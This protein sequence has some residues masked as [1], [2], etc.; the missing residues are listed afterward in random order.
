MIRGA[1][2]SLSRTGLLRVCLLGLA[3]L[4]VAPAASAQES[5]AAAGPVAESLLPTTEHWIGDLDG[6]RKR[7]TIRLLVPYSKTFYFVDKGGKQFGI[8]YDVGHAFEEWLNKREKTKTLKI[9]VVFIPVARDRLLSGLAD[10]LGDIAAGNI[11]I[12]EERAK[13]VQFGDPFAKDIKEVLVTGPTAAPIATL[14]D[15]AGR[16]IYVRRSSS[17][18][19]HL[20]SLSSAL[21]AKGLKPIV[22]SELDDELEDEDV[23]EMV[24]AGLLP[25][26][27]VDEHKAQIWTSVFTTLTVRSDLA[28][29]DGGEIAWAMRKDDPQLLAV[30]NEFTKT[31]KIGTTFGNILKKRYLGSDSFVKRSTSTEEIEKFQAIAEL[32]RKYGQQYDFDW[33]MIAAQGYQESKLDQ[34]ARSP[35]GAVGVMQLMPKTAADPTVGISNIESVDN[36]IHAGVKY[37]RTLVG[38]YLDDP[39]LDR[40]N[41]TLMAF[42]AYNAGPGNLRKFRKLA[43]ESGLDPNVWFHNVEHAAAEIVGRE[44]VQYVSNIYKYYVAYRLANE[45]NEER[46]KAKQGVAPAPQ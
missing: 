6:M 45:R 5:P 36:N 18:F 30:V 46:S 22:I 24:N 33:L 21:E 38:K 26:V 25:W 40:K 17:Y 9:S 37:L 19:E 27:V 20:Q 4:F 16:E 15:L 34:S 1:R 12:T 43:A 44:T 10:G 39:A 41:R 13:L 11:T 3:P 14:D 29:N 31:H 8:T 2:L 7:R 28:I 23:M 35:R 32:F 42:A